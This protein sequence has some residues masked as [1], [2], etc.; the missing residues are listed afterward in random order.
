MHLKRASNNK[1]VQRHDYRIS[2]DDFLGLVGRRSLKFIMGSWIVSY[3]ASTARHS[4]ISQTISSINW[5]WTRQLIAR[6]ASE[7]PGH[8]T[9]SLNYFSFRYLASAER[10]TSK[11]WRKTA[12]QNKQKF[13]WNLQSWRD[14]EMCSRR[15]RTCRG[16]D[17]SAASITLD[18]WKVAHQLIDVTLDWTFSSCGF[19]KVTWRLELDRCQLDTE[20]EAKLPT[21]VKEGERCQPLA[22]E[23]KKKEKNSG[24]IRSWSG[25]YLP[26]RL[27]Q[28]FYGYAWIAFR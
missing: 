27:L 16:F 28:S 3:Y 7:T 1:T 21:P 8:D 19:P 24:R 14:Q 9:Q 18:D 11:S 2:T 17:P 22:V 12:N 23:N 20:S 13:E 15:A 26:P 6:H 4:F 5:N 10:L 25:L